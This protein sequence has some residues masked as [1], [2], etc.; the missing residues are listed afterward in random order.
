MSGRS[1]RKGVG[2]LKTGPKVAQSDDGKSTENEEEKN[3]ELKGI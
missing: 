2:Y 1:L 3:F